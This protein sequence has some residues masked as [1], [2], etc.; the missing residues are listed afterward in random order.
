MQAAFPDMVGN[1]ALRQQLFREL[2]DHS[3]SHAYILEGAAGMGKA[4]KPGRLHGSG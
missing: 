3:L 1:L 4:Q 2:K